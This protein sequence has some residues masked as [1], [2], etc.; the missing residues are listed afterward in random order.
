MLYVWLPKKPSA[1]VD[2]FKCMDDAN[3]GA[4]KEKP[5]MQVCA[6]N[7]HEH[8]LPRPSKRRLAS[9]R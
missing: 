2:I 1:H 4:R 7:L 8:V 6:N 5:L 3:D 9:R